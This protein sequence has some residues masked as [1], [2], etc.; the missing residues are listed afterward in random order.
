MFSKSSQFA[1]SQKAYTN[2]YSRISYL[3]EDG[4]CI[5]GMQK[6]SMLPLIIFDAVVNVR[7]ILSSLSANPIWQILV[8]PYYALR[9]STSRYASANH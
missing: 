1:T 8:L 2:I 7:T 6:K 3:R 4:V 9:H 5:I